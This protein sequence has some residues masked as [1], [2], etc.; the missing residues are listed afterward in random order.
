MGGDG[1]LMQPLAVPDFEL[2]SPDHILALAGESL[3]EYARRVAKEHA[4]CSEDFIGG[5]SFGGMVAAEIAR[6]TPVRGLILLG[7]CIHPERLPLAYKWIEK[8]GPLVP[9]W[10]L[11][12]RVWPPLVRWRFSPVSEKD[13][14][15]LIAM[16][17][18]CPPSQI[19][20]FGKMAVQWRGIERIDCPVLS[21]HGDRDRIIPVAGA[22]PGVIL[23]NAGHAFTLTH[24]AET[25]ALISEFIAK[26]EGV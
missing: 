23:R 4:I 5:A 3:S 26:T 17:K 7:S 16:A 19:R 13:E 1:R 24:G 18:D 11:G 21:I 14:R 15:I 25:S 6:Q 9:N 20:A 2:L 8:L 12:M 10:A 22:E